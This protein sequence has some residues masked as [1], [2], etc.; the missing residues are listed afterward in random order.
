MGRTSSRALF[1]QVVQTPV[2]VQH[3][4]WIAQSDT[5]L[6]LKFDFQNA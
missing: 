5:R 3:L 2:A 4:R 1:Y 6:I